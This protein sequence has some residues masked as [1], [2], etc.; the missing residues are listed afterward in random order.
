M[1]SPGFADLVVAR[2][3]LDDWSVIS[4]WAGDEGWNPGLSDAPSFFAQDPEGFFIGRIDGQ[5]VSAVSVVTYD[6]DY[7]FLGFYLVRPDLRGRGHGLATWKT[8][9][10]HMRRPDRRSGR[11]GGAAGQLPQVR[12]R[13]R[14]PHRPVHRN[15]AAW[16]RR[17]R[18]AARRSGRLRVD[19]GVRQ[20]LL[21]GRP[22]PLPGTVAHR[23][24][25]PH[26]RPRRRRPPHRLRGDPARPRPPARGPAVRRHRRGCPRPP[27]G[28]G[29]RRSRGR[30]RHRHPRVERA[31]RR[32]RRGVRPHP[33]FETARMY[34][35]PVRPFSGERVYGVTT[36][37][38]G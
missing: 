8:A 25:P 6:A 14:P 5:P 30:G 31:G 34:T 20:C 9:L 7:A 13:T 17:H 38:L 10:A 28:A 11:C 22:P 12:L 19:R 18:G 15:R 4:G 29:R 3:S 35:G 27:A 21:P 36:L 1:T 23:S 37:E 26:L 24:R 32:P 16:N 33:S 2:A